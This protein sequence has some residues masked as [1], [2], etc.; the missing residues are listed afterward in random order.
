MCG[1]A[2]IFQTKPYSNNQDRV[3]IAQNMCD[4]LI[5]RGPDSGGIWSDTELPI[6]LC[7]RRLSIIDLS[8]EGHQPMLSNSGRFIICFNGEIYNFLEIKKELDKYNINFKG[9]SDTEILLAAFEN[10]GISRTLQKIKGM[11]AIALFDRKERKIYFIRDHLGKKPLYI[12]FANNDLVFASELRAFREHPEFNK[13]IN[14]NAATEYF[15]FG[16]IPDPL[17]IYKSVFS[18]K[19]ANMLIIDL[20]NLNVAK[21]IS[22][23]S[24]PYWNIKDSIDESRNK[25]EENNNLSEN[26]ILSKFDNQLKSSVEKRMIS[27]VSLGAFLSGGIDSSLVVSVMQ[28]LSQ[29]PIKTF[30]I[31]FEEKEYNEADKAALVANHLGCDH[32][33]IIFSAKEAMNMIDDITNIYDEPFSDVSQI[34]TALL[35]RFTKK[36]VSVALSGD[37]GDEILGGYNRYIAAP[38][39]WNKIKYIPSPIRKSL[40]SMMHLIPK[41]TLE[42]ISGGRII[43]ADEKIQKISSIL[44]LRDQNEIY[45]RL[46]V[47]NSDYKN[48]ISGDSNFNLFNVMEPENLNFAEKMMFY[49]S[50]FYL[51][52][53]ILV[54]VDR[55]SM[56]YSLETRAPLLDIDLF[57]L[58]WSLPE[59]YKIRDKSGKWILKKLLSNY[60]PGEII[61]QPKQGF[62][63][64]I[65]QWIRGPLMDWTYSTLSK[66]NIDKSSFINF[67]EVTRILD[68]HMSSKFNHGHY[69]W[70]ILVFQSWVNKYS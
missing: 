21:D 3:Q 64:P 62:N 22:N 61:N 9:R 70:S 42:K 13:E 69:L 46:L 67:V 31:G 10:I 60:V 59:K 32:E 58:C 47:K 57:K 36:S 7:H 53:D 20:D 33:E 54:K 28:S 11:F 52:N 25:V 39:I 23:E 43:H 68:E 65:G 55:A 30:T 45:E 37:G 24:T 2:G 5:N 35:S 12:G 1:I 14:I 34:P 41:D 66:E 40:S 49:D 19:A 38:R 44:S 27:D 18:L 8:P 29:S 16:Y 63:V 17:S 50:T 56:H 6:T 26:E 51:P 15:K 4:S 48:I